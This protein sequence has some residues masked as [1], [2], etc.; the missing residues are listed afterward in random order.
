MREA[1]GAAGVVM[2]APNL[3]R[4]TGYVTIMAMSE[5]D[6]FLQGEVVGT[7]GAKIKVCL[8]G[9]AMTN[10]SIKLND[11]KA[12]DG[13]KNIMVATTKFQIC[14]LYQGRLHS[15]RVLDATYHIQ[16]L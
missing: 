3:E 14:L 15:L 16:K 7:F 6:L 8:P 12:T 9:S 4:L 5:E 11:Q 10:I 13:A 1:G 2:T